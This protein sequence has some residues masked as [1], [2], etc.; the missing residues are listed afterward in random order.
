MT[1]K[2]NDILLVAGQVLAAIIQIVMALAAAALVIA[3]PAVVF[4]QDAINAEIG[5]EAGEA[6]SGLPIWA[7]LGL[8]CVGLVMV[9]I[10]FA[11]FGRLRAIIATVGEGDPFVPENADRLN[12]MAWL[13]LALQA[14]LIPAAGFGLFLAKWADQFEH[15]NITIE[16]GLDL[17]GILMVILL[18]IL[19]R[20]FKHG[21]AM[22]E[23]LEGT[24]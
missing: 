7:T 4:L 9:G 15:Q 11:F 18:F 22:R 20:V 2:P 8:I 16:A 1:Q 5:V 3:I 24:V 17:S 12:L 23:D 21:A 13:L 6:A 19:A 14:M 10:V